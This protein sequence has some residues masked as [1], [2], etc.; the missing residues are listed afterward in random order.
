MNNDTCIKLL[1]GYAYDA[2][3]LYQLT[4]PGYILFFKGEVILLSNSSSLNSLWGC[5]HS[6]LQGH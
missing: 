2:Q 4:K 1:L 3:V 6:I 5:A